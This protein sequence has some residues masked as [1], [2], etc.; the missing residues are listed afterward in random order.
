MP[1]LEEFLARL[2]PKI[3]RKVKTAQ[4]T[5]LV[6]YPVAS[7]G[8]NRALGGGIGA[9]RITLLYG[10]SGSGKSL[11]A[12]QTIGILQKQG[13]SCAYFDVEGTYE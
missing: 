13:L 5:E 2:D 4:N 1:G 7:I 6:K 9:G 12:L 11:L 3:A 8:L 10:N